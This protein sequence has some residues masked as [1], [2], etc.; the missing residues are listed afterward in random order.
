MGSYPY[1]EDGQAGANLVLRST[2]EDRLKLAK[3][4]LIERLAPILNAS[5]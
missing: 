1:F 2:N 5:G 3:A 4:D